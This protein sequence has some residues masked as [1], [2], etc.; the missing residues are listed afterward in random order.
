MILKSS[1]RK[2]IFILTILFLVFTSS[3]V[4]A[5]YNTLLPTYVDKEVLSAEQ[6]VKSLNESG[7]FSFGFITDIHADSGTYSPMVNVE[8]FT[9][10]K[11]RGLVKF[12]ICAG[13]ITNGEYEDF[14]SGKALQNLEFFADKIS[15]KNAFSPV[16]FARGNHDCNYKL[17]A[18]VAISGK[19]YYD[20]VLKRLNTNGN[21]RVCTDQNNNDC[22]YRVVFDENN[23]GGDY[24]YADYRASNIRV[25][26]LNPFNGGNYEYV[27]GDNQLNFVANQV[28]NFSDK[29]NPSDWQVIF[30]THTVEESTAHNEKPSDLDKLYGIINAFQEGKNETVENIPVNYASQGKGTVIAIISGHHHLD[31]TMIK[32]NILVITVRSA[33][34][35]MDRQDN[36]NERYNEDDISFDIFSVDKA[37]KTLYA[38]KVGRGNDRV[39]SYDINNLQEKTASQR[40]YTPT[41]EQDNINI[42]T[43]KNHKNEEYVFVT[44]N[45]P[46]KEKTNKAWILSQ[47]KK[48][49]IRLLNNM[50]SDYLTTFTNENGLSKSYIFN[51]T[52]SS[53]DPL[54]FTFN[55]TYYAD[56]NRDLKQ[57]FGYDEAQLRNHYLQYGIKDGRKASPVFDVDYYLKENKDVQNLC[58]GNYEQAYQHFVNFGVYENRKTSP[59]F[60]SASYL[61]RYD[62]L[63]KAFGEN[64]YFAGTL[65]FATAGLSE[66]RH[67][68]SFDVADF[69]NRCSTSVK[70]SLGGN[71][72]KYY[73]LAQGAKVV[74][75]SEIDENYYMFDS[76]L[77]YSLYPDLQAAFG[78]NTKALKN[79]YYTCGIKEGR[80]ASFVF[81][82]VYY[83]NKFDDLKNAFG[84]NG[85][86]AAY[87]HFINNGMKEGRTASPYFN[88][89]YYLSKYKDLD[90]AYNGEYQKALEHFV[91]KGMKEGRIASKV[92]DVKVYRNNYADL[93]KAFTDKWREYYKHYMIC[94]QRE[95]RVCI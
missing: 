13:D 55:S 15:P 64:N 40:S 32:N 88:A 90:N 44:S 10:V 35:L 31:S 72:I 17:D 46:F 56:M 7:A 75:E 70:N 39:W 51:K 18:N 66:G 45:S 85:Y 16:F 49:Y 86:E 28:L 87:N 36:S 34:I 67:S 27:F 33:N 58:N 61:Q 11:D 41:E 50:P 37:S 30:L 8:A 82:P 22:S 54:T 24:Y 14:K 53:I 73:A 71:Y 60:N 91:E 23:L 84:A 68:G 20:S 42:F 63:K 52:K 65:H 81:D 3:T 57:K 89:R 12:G 48:T 38:T 43:I 5:G 4:L 92:F 21:Y 47:D 26:V 25:C 76:E 6:H 1:K 77:Y 83:L 9:K 74:E 79:H 95:G 62:D 94:G 69:Y 29:T 59:Y 78:N 2:I 93:N 80:V 19:Q